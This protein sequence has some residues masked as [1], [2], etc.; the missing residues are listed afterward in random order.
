MSPA[1]ARSPICWRNDFSCAA[2]A[3]MMAGE[4]SDL[5]LRREHQADVGVALETIKMICAALV[6]RDDIAAQ[7]GLLP[8]FLFDLRHH[9]AAGSGG[10]VTRGAGRHAGIHAAGHVLDR[11]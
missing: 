7:A 5:L 6:E 9:L 3:S 1:S 2:L 4:K 11:L 8:R 10:G